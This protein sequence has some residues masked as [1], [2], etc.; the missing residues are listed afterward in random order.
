MKNIMFKKQL[1]NNNESIYPLV[2][3]GLNEGTIEYDYDYTKTLSKRKRS[4]NKEQTQDTNRFSATYINSL[5]KPN[6]LKFTFRDID[7]NMIKCPTGST[8]IETPV[9]NDYDDSQWG[10]Q[11]IKNPFE[12]GETEVTQELFEAVMGFNYSV[13]KKPKNPVELVTWYDCADFCNKLSKYFGFTPYYYIKNPSYGTGWRRSIS[14]YHLLKLSIGNVSYVTTNDKSNGFR[15]PKE[16][17][18]QWAALAGTNNTYAGTNATDMDKIKQ[19]AWFNDNSGKEPHPVA[20][21][22][23][24]EWGFYDMSG[25]V[26]EWC[27]NITYDQSSSFSQETK[28]ACRGGSYGASIKSIKNRGSQA[29]GNVSTKTGFRIARNI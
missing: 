22:L 26:D 8:F 6:Y 17:E 29:R 25:N 10:Q 2:L 5:K 12:L 9:E 27:D 19:V 11:E 7:F 24:N 3:I 1:M 28:Y 20:Q 4:S 14:D 21:K 15:L 18:W 16:W 23:P 13:F